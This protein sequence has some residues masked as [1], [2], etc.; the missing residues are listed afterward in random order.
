L[1]TILHR[2]DLAA[3]VRTL[4]LH[5]DDFV[6][7]G[8][9]GD[10]LPKFPIDALDLNQ[11]VEAITT[12]RV[13]YARRWVDELRNGNMDAFV[14][15]LL[16]RLH[17]LR[18]LVIGPN[19]AKQTEFLGMLL[20]SA[21]WLR[22]DHG[23]PTFQHLRDVK[24]DLDVDFMRENGGRNT[25]SVLPFFYL[26]EVQRLWISLD[27]PVTFYWPTHTAPNLST[28]TSLTLETIREEHLSQLLSVTPRLKTLCWQFYYCEDH[29]HAS[30]TSLIDLDKIGTA[31]VHVRNTLK[32]LAISAIHDIG[33]GYEFPNL[34]IKGSLEAL[35]DFAQLERLEITLQFL[36]ASFTPATGI[37]LKDVVPRNIHSLIITDD[38]QGDC[39]QNEWKDADLYNIIALW[40]QDPRVPKPNL[41]T[42]SLL[43]NLPV[44]DWDSTMRQAL[45]KLFDEWGIEANITKT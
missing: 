38:L 1:R 24:Y 2:P 19:F 15:L 28:I 32:E 5:G 13:P 40:L 31:L 35:V 4:G 44:Y 18:R 6:I 36:V 7:Y 20:Y 17:G 21:L 25:A 8:P 33:T 12:T 9:F 11:A 27:N 10:N 45:I 22:V 41:R 43:F 39:D 29:Q 34:E 42:I 14:A 30:C 16:S 37:D 23:F 3:H 26:P